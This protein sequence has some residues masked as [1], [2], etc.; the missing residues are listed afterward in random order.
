MILLTLCWQENSWFWR[1]W[2]LMIP[3]RCEAFIALM[4]LCAPC[5]VHGW[6]PLNSNQDSWAL[7]ELP[8][9]S[10]LPHWLSFLDTLQIY[11]VQQFCLLSGPWTYLEGSLVSWM[12]LDLCYSLVSW[13]L[14]LFSGPW[15]YM[16]GGFS[17]VLSLSTGL[18]CTAPGTDWSVLC[19]GVQIYLLTVTWCGIVS[20]WWELYLQEFPLA[21]GSPCL[22]Q[23][24]CLH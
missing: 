22:F 1:F 16:V 11:V 12:H 19:L 18:C 6:F 21:P 2:L 8:L 24:W 4:A 7:Y 14:W 20:Y 3:V 10:D 15:M 13:Q 9:D 5:P 23:W 17:P